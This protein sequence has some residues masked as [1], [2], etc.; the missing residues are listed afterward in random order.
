MPRTLDFALVAA[1]A[2]A[3]SA[4]AQDPPTPPAPEAAEPAAEAPVTHAEG[5]AAEPGVD[6]IY[7]AFHEAYRKLDAE[8]VA[9]TYDQDAL[10]LSPGA[11]VRQGRASVTEGFQ[12]LFGWAR[13]GGAQIGITFEIVE[14]QLGPEM[15]YDVGYFR[16]TT[17]REDGSTA[18]NRGKFV[19]VLRPG[20]EGWRIVVDSFSPVQQTPPDGAP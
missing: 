16:M 5:V 17:R 1:L 14:R 6:R 3:S 13:E 8:A 2:F 4:V 10:Y 18:V 15:G 9:A 11:E 19:V 7:R 12:R 20:D